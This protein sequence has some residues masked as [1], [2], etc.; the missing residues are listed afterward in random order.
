MKIL[1]LTAMWLAGAAVQAQQAPAQEATAPEV[2][3]EVMTCAQLKAE[4]QRQLAIMQYTRSN[5]LDAE[6]SDEVDM[7]RLGERQGKRS[8]ALGAL[9]AAAGLAGNAVAVGQ[10]G[11]AADAMMS[12]DKMDRD[13][14]L[15]RGHLRDKGNERIENQ[16]GAHFQAITEQYRRRGCTG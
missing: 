1:V 6:L 9:Q 2:K 3:I 5:D 7:I 12:V 10:A 11:R 15:T 16:A 14:I 13:A 4:G 8:I